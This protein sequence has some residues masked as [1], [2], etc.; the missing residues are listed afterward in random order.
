ME[1]PT[2]TEFQKDR[3]LSGRILGVAD[4][5]DFC[6]RITHTQSV[7]SGLWVRFRV[8]MSIAINFCLGSR[9]VLTYLEPPQ[10]RVRSTP[11]SQACKRDL[12]GASLSGPSPG[13]RPLSLAGNQGDWEGGAPGRPQ[14]DACIRLP[15]PR[16]GYRQ[17][18]LI[19]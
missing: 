6:E 3:F 18:N 15:V 16:F 8:A 4:W 1:L 7:W 13:E 19:R 9:A 2:R 17:G 12:P 10:I 5:G 14:N 11:R